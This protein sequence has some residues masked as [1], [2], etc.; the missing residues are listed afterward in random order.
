RIGQRVV[1]VDSRG[2]RKR[3]LSGVNALAQHPAQNPFRF[4]A[5]SSIIDTEVQGVASDRPL[6]LRARPLGYD[7]PVVDDGEAIGEAIGLF[8]VLRGQEHR[9]PA[10]G[11]RAHYVPDLTAASR[12]EAGR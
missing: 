1:V 8:E 3:V 6:Q 12:V 7:P 9:G 4:R 10:R 2:K 5:T 11:D